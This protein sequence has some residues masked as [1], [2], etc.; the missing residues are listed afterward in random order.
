MKP[1]LTVCKN[2]SWL[3]QLI[4]CL[5]YKQQGD[6]YPSMVEFPKSSPMLRQRRQLHIITHIGCLSVYPCS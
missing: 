3:C 2:K 4:K 6:H 5:Q 1:M